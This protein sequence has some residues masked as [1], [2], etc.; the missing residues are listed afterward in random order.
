MRPRILAAGVLLTALLGL[1]ACDTMGSASSPLAEAAGPP[2]TPLNEPTSPTGAP[3][4]V[5]VPAG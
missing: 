3:P 2:A 1:A 5:T 4:S